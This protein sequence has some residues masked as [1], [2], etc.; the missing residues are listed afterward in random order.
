MGSL[1]ESLQFQDPIFRGN[2]PFPSPQVRKSGP[3]IP[4]KKKRLSAPP[5]ERGPNYT[6]LHIVMYSIGRFNQRELSMG[7]VEIW[8][9][10]GF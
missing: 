4:T 10:S 6:Q 8:R 7:D 3:H 5:T 1:L 9:K 2:N